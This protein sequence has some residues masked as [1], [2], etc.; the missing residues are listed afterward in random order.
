MQDLR[1][2]FRALRASPIVTVVAALSLT[3][4][5]GAN[6]AIFSLVNSLLLRPLP[7]KEPER[8]VMLSTGHDQ[9][10]S[11]FSYA[12]F[13]QVRHLEQFDGA[14]AWN[15]GG[16]LTLSDGADT[17]L[18]VDQFVSG[19]YF[20]T[21]GVRAV[22]G[23]TLTPADDVPG[24][25]PDGLV[26]M[27]SYRLWQ[28]RFAGAANIV[29][30]RITLERTPVTIVGVMPPG[31]FGL[32]VGRTFDVALPIREQPLLSR[33]AP[34]TDDLVWLRITLRMKPT[35]SLDEATA[36]LRAVQP[37]IRAGAMPKDGQDARTF[38]QDPLVLVPAGS[39]M[40]PLR[41][42][43]E[44]PLVTILVVVAL[45]LVIAC[46]NI[47]NLMLARCAARRHELSI[48]VALGAS[49]WRLACQFLA[50][51]LLLASI[52]TATGVA[53]G[54]WATRAIVAQLS[55]PATPVDLY[56]SLDWRVLTF[57]GAVMVVT[58][59]IAGAVP[60][61]RA[62]GVPPIGAL[63]EHGRSAVGESGGHASRGLIV[64]QVAL[65]LVL[66]VAAGLFVRTFERLQGASLGFDRD[67]VLVVTVAAPTVP[68]TERRVL[69]QRLVDAA[70]HV[71]GVAAAGGSFNP[72]IVG[73]LIGEF[74]VSEPGVPPPPEAEHITQVG[75][76]SPGW[77]SAY[78]T[79]LRAG[80]DFDDRDTLTSPPVMLVNESF[81]RRFLPNQ[82]P[83]GKPMAVTFRMPPF[84]DVLLGTKT[85]VGVVGDSVYRAIR[86]PRRPTIYFAMA[87]RPGPLLFANFFIAVRASAG[88][89]LLLTRNLSA[90]L[91]AVNPDLTL[92]F[93]GLSDQV[94]DSL[95]QDRV[96][97]MLS[98]FFG[99]LALL[100]AA[101]GLYGV[102]AYA[103]SRRRT[104][105]GIRMALGAAPSAI[106]RLVLVRVSW[107]VGLG[108]L[109]GAGLSVWASTFVASLLYGLEPRDPTTLT[110][111]IATLAAVAALAAWLPAWRASRLDPS[112]AL[113]EG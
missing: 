85:I 17:Q 41:Q 88:S 74:V 96:V 5:I 99:A 28:T 84:G 76:T 55:T 93:R 32:I 63:K 59:M 27:I 72:P 58:T 9:N 79:P 83:V 57:T 75:E 37:Q 31:F 15:A 65:S 30:A 19:E 6:T 109:V 53:F 89:P 33:A 98:G 16:T 29:G 26:A 4:G 61:L 49:R 11:Q 10:D 2:A 24:G 73:S 38:L 42:R 111:A 34:L 14:V 50:E 90:A 91:T 81:V 20:S 82:D 54:A 56:S 92:T 43:F 103:V 106:A 35:Q 104:E 25:G 44:R 36:A 21:L 71:P 69:Y 18:V 7:V 108:V 113:R 47:A 40:T 77:F 80:R 3:L 51:S 22:I 101:L 66:V 67:R 62:T 95:A 78:G 39:R 12:L 110:V 23:R 60:A 112:E 94:N 97:A 100:L 64:G 46:A 52:G 107:L 102:T 13:E 45:V 87:Q 48:R 1:L 70:T 86:D 8:L 105:I 68:A